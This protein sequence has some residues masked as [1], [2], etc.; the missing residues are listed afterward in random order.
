MTPDADT[1]RICKLASTTIAS[2]ET[3]GKL[4]LVCVTDDPLAVADI[5]DCSHMINGDNLSQE[6]G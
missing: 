3:I 2:T 4:V 5:A 6:M 1:N